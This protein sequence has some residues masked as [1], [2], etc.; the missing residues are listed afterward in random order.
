MKVQYIINNYTLGAKLKSCP[1]ECII[2]QERTDRNRTI[3]VFDFASI[4]QKEFTDKV[5][6]KKGWIM[7]SG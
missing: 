6:A 7:E 4:R 3:V 5:L 2:R 1:K